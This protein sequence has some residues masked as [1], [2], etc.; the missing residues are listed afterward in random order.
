[1]AGA[2]DAESRPFLLSASGTVDVPGFDLRSLR[3][4][5][6]PKAFKLL[7][8]RALFFNGSFL[9]TLRILADPQ[10]NAALTRM[11][12]STTF[13][14]YPPGCLAHRAARF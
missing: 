10:S 4:T 3:L 9:E 6:R 12:V 13:R 2:T 14:D 5:E 7:R 11:V 1:M 8:L